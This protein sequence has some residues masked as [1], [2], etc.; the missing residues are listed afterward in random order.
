[1]QSIRERVLKTA[2]YS[3]AGAW[4]QNVFKAALRQRVK[5]N[6]ANAAGQVRVMS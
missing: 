6:R 3:H 4:Q 5:Q 2:G 1:M